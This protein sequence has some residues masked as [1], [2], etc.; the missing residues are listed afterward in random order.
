MTVR[1]ASGVVSGRRVTV[2]LCDPVEAAL[3]LSRR[4]SSAHLDTLVQLLIGA[5]DVVDE[6]GEDSSRFVGR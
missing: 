3:I 4:M 5:P 1:K 2:P 6:V